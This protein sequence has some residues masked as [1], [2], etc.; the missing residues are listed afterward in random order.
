MVSAH[1]TLGRT[2]NMTAQ[3][4]VADQLRITQEYLSW[5]DSFTR[6]DVLLE[7]RRRLPRA[8]WLKLLGQLWA[9]CDNVG[10]R[11]LI[12]RKVLGV[13]G[14]LLPMMDDDE[15]AAYSKCTVIAIRPAMPPSRR[16]RSRPRGPRIRSRTPGMAARLRPTPHPLGLR[17]I[18]RP[19]A[20]CR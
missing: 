15:R 6:L 16:F 3:E 8:V 7:N 17:R 18:R 20:R 5:A 1:A 9:V 10:K 4:Q 12:L 13:K 2:G 11:R 14:P 19:Q